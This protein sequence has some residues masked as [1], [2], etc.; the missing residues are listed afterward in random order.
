MHYLVNYR[1]E[2]CYVVYNLGAG[3]ALPR[4]L[5]PRNV[6]CC[7]QLGGRPCIT[8]STIASK[9]VMLCTTWGPAVHYLVNYRLET[10]YVVHNSRAGRA[11]PRQLSPRNVLCCAQLEG[12]QCITSSTI[13]SKRVMLCTTRGPAVHYLVNYRLETCYV[14]HNSRAGRAL[15]RQLSPRN[16]L[17]CVQLGGRQCITSSTIASKR[18]SL[19]AKSV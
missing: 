10:C 11:L 14:V 9:R 8:S 3:R 18:E 7:V 4:Q 17:C 12:R 15:P 16:V 19:H 2:T 5:S 6:L 1:L 13:A